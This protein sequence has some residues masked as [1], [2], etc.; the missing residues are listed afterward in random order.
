MSNTTQLG[1]ERILNQPLDM[2]LLTEIAGI[3]NVTNLC[4]AIK[5]DAGI[6]KVDASCE[7]PKYN[8]IRGARRVVKNKHALIFYDHPVDYRFE[9]DDKP[10]HEKAREILRKYFINSGIVASSLKEHF[11]RL[12][13]LKS[14]PIISLTGYHDC[15]EDE[16]FPTLPVEIAEIISKDSQRC[17]VYVGGIDCHFVP[18]NRHGKISRPRLIVG[19]NIGKTEDNPKSLDILSELVIS[20][21]SCAGRYHILLDN[22]LSYEVLKKVQE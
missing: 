21:S 22:I 16:L 2:G 9:L 5:C 19:D 11:A 12:P 3:K 4:H 6:E 18:E 8:F 7:P 14:L 17:I 10:E 15:Y 13:Q 1:L 20:R